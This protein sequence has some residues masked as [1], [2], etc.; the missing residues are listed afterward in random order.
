MIRRFLP[1]AL[2]ARLGA[3]NAS[4][5]HAARLAEQGRGVPAFKIYAHAARHGHAEAQFRVGCCY[6]EGAGVPPSRVEAIRWLERAALQHHVDAKIY[7]A[8]LMLPG[9][10]ESSEPG[11]AASPPATSLFNRDA[12]PRNFAAAMKWARC[13]ALRGSPEGQAILAH[14]L[15]AGPDGLRDEDAA[16]LWYERAAAGGSANGMFGY[17]LSLAR[18]SGKPIDQAKVTELIRGAAESGH[19]AAARALG[20]IYLHGDGVARDPDEAAHWLSISAAAGN[21]QAQAD[22]ANLLLSGTGAPETLAKVRRWFADAAIAGDP[23]AQYNFGLCL[24]EGIGGERDEV[25]AL[26]WLREAADRV[27]NAQYCYGRM[28]AAGRGTEANPQEGRSW[29]GRAAASGMADA[30]F[31]LAE[32]L[33]TG[34]GGPRDHAG[35]ETLLEKAAGKGHVGAMFGLAAL[36]DG[37]YDIPVDRPATLRWLR[38]AAEHGHGEAQ[39]ILATKQGSATPDHRAS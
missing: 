28:L 2:R 8:V 17:A 34:T 39:R 11:A 29:L 3:R 35:A 22:L 36:K 4:I 23:V 32:M 33:V 15:S 27:A 18:R 26:R 13:A 20:Q 7:L 6:L 16:H 1:R 19:M 30:Q 38:E 31:A 21:R 24:A 10:G 25:G 14:I 12:A 9:G 37:G 5:R